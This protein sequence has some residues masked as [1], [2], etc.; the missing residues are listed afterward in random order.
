M[1]PRLQIKPEEFIEIAKNSQNLIIKSGS[2]W[3]TGFQYVVREGDYYYYTVAKSPLDL[4]ASCK[5]KEVKSI[6]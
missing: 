4:P 5:V 6:L 3:L 1:G 2:G